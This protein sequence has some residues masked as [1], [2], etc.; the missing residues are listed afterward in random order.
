[1]MDCLAAM[2]ALNTGSRTATL[3]LFIFFYVWQR[4]SSFKISITTSNTEHS[5]SYHCHLCLA[6]RGL[7]IGVIP[8]TT[9]DRRAVYK[10]KQDYGGGRRR[11]SDRLT[12]GDQHHVNDTKMAMKQE[13]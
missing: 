2:S 12:R 3:F 8:G 11:G 1:M 10:C 5:K 13:T 4:A 9:T 7:V 6:F